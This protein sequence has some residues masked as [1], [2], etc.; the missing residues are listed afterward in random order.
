MLEG[1]EE[2]LLESSVQGCSALCAHRGELQE[3]VSEASLLLSS[4]RLPGLRPPPRL[5]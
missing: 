3:M 4:A 5:P 2:A 1:I